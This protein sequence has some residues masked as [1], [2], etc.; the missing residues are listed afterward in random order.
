MQ[1]IEQVFI[2]VTARKGG[3][4]PTARSA[5]ILPIDLEEILASADAFCVPE[6]GR[7]DLLNLFFH[8]LPSG[9][10]TIGRLVPTLEKSG[11][12]NSPAG[13]PFCLQYMVVSPET[14]LRFGNNPIFLYQAVL[15]RGL[16]PAA[17]RG[18]ERLEPVYLDRPRKWF[19]IPLLRGMAAYPGA[20]I[21]AKLADTVLHSL[22]TVVTGGPQTLYV[23]SALF[24]LFPIRFRPEI[25]FTSGVFFEPDRYFRVTGFSGKN[26][27][28]ADADLFCPAP[29]L[30]LDQM[31]NDGKHTPPAH[32]WQ[33][34]VQEILES[35]NFDFFQTRLISHDHDYAQKIESDVP[36]VPSAD[37]LDDLGR[38]WLFEM[39][40]SGI[41][42]SRNLPSGPDPAEK[43]G[44]AD[45]EPEEK[46]IF[47]L[48]QTGEPAGPPP[49]ISEKLR[50]WLLNDNPQ[51]GAYFFQDKLP[52]S[53]RFVS[54]LILRSGRTPLFSPLQRL[55]AEYPGEEE[56]L[57][58]LD[59]MVASVLSGS[60]EAFDR[61]SR[62]WRDWL[63][64][65]DDDRKWRICEEYTHFV[66]I[67]ITEGADCS[68]SDLANRNLAALDLLNL[69][70]N[71]GEAAEFSFDAD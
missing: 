33:A 8:Y 9:A 15:S 45:R 62:F 13:S 32:G 64:E 12:Q 55:L 2:P 53:P 44:S 34:F 57:R 3:R 37:E 38:R 66:Q 50:R 41:G 24:N 29:F 14:F 39:N 48:R 71:E 47:R 16:L 4:I 46:K 68:D 5:G 69:F 67:A 35:G 6:K 60:D 59:R 10:C 49:K 56:Q 18:G 58:L 7:F 25:T 51:E 28:A 63:G 20:E 65:A 30:D 42:K 43:G 23:L 17:A 54:P 36:D 70:L 19:D 31:L 22:R 40:S 26:R 61:L 21:M 11:T 27:P 52:K 1:K